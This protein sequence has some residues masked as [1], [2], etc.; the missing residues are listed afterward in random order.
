MLCLLLCRTLL[1]I[2]HRSLSSKELQG[3]IARQVVALAVSKPTTSQENAI[4]Q[5]LEQLHK[6][7]QIID[8]LQS[9]CY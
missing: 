4:Q 2:V 6:M 7:K 5:V 8:L 9:E 1:S 3:N